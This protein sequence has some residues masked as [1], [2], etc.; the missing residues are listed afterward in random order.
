M[1]TKASKSVRVRA[2]AETNPT[3]AMVATPEFVYV[4]AGSGLNRWNIE[5]GELLRLS[6]EHGLPSDT[7]LSMAHDPAR[8]QL[9]IATDV[10]ITRYQTKR[11]NFTE[12]PP[13][14][15]ILGVKSFENSV[16]APAQG[17]GVW[18]GLENGLF[19][20]E[21]NGNWSNT[22]IDVR[23]N[24]LLQDTQGMLWIGTDKGLM[25]VDQKRVAHSLSKDEGCKFDKVRS[26]TEFGSGVL[27]MAS[28]SAGKTRAALAGQQGCV[29]YKIPVNKNWLGVIRSAEDTYVLS[30]D[31]IYSVGVPRKQEE[32]VELLPGFNLPA[33]A[34]GKEV[35]GP[36]ALR[37]DEVEQ[38]VPKHASHIATNG[39]QLFVAT[40]HLGTMVWRPGDPGISWL[41]VG[42]LTAD[43]QNLSV[44]CVGPSDCFVATGTSKLWRWNGQTFT[45]D[46]DLRR[47][48]AVLALQDGR[49]LALRDSAGVGRTGGASLSLALFEAEQWMEVEG[50]KIETPGKAV[51]LT[52]ARQGPDGLV[53]LAISYV[54]GRRRTVPFGVAV[55]DLE[56]STVW[57]HRASFDKRLGRQGILPVP[58]DVSGIAFMGEDAI[59]LA[60]SQGAARLIGEDIKT[61]I[62]ADGLRSELLRGVVCTTGGM[63]YTASS[64]GLGAW[65]GE[66]W[67]YPP[68]LRTAINDL[69][70]GKQGR[71]W[72]ATDRGLGVYDGARVRRLD[73]RRGLLE[74]VLLDV[75]ADNL[76]RIWAMSENG[77]VLVSP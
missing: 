6:A 33:M 31:E 64:R 72:L 8:E 75:E 17:G 74:N 54:Q 14:A 36:A 52:T 70:M 25:W 60:S 62:E 65:D 21:P 76:G 27:V 67:S 37:F 18:I 73:T 34:K 10:G 43:A 28:S 53:W 57:Y 2:F 56:L 5:T 3:R 11:S 30:S 7:V 4:A 49:I 39:E 51:H 44:A 12:L 59:W 35:I 24:A 66:R 46:G 63:V 15:E 32:G 45:N 29:T 16:L 9:W 71:L 20:A 69:A 41:R 47:V 22:G 1:K 50:V 58:V 26:L 55:V 19:Y 77:L 61:F 23:V 40:K 42:E 48:H 13:P 68:E 38:A